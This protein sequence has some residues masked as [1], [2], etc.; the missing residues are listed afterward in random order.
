MNIKLEQLKKQ[1]VIT[2]KEDIVASTWL[3]GHPSLGESDQV[4]WAYEIV[5]DEFE[6]KRYKLQHVKSKKM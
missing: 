3:S 2:N 5:R 4:V 1:S 6:R